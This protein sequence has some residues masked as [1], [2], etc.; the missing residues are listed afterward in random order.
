VAVLLDETFRTDAYPYGYK[1][2]I[3][4]DLMKS[5]QTNRVDLVVLNEAP[6]LLRHRV[7]AFGRPVYVRSE[8]RRIEFESDIMQRYPE[9]KRLLAAHLS[10]GKEQE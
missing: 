2:K 3:T 1:A 5:L 4:T 10:S 7:I 6:Y 8:A 9:M